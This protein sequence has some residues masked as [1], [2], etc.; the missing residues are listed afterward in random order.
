MGRLHKG[1]WACMCLSQHHW[2]CKTSKIKDLFSF[3]VVFMVL[4][5]I[6]MPPN[7]EKYGACHDNTDWK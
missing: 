4:K 3:Y 7:T 5:K 1:I 2:T 6:M